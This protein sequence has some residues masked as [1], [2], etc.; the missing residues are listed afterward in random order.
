MPQAR[1]AWCWYWQTIKKQL[2]NREE[3]VAV[4]N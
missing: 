4:I 3:E 2:L 1:Y